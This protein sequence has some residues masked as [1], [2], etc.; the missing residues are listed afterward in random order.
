MN[1][2]LLLT[3]MKPSILVGVQAV[4]E[5]VIMRVPGTYA[6]VVRNPEGI[7]RKLFQSVTER[8]GSGESQLSVEWYL[9]FKP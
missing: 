6:T 9:Y 4:I 8:P 2:F 1:R 3:T 5:G 7:N